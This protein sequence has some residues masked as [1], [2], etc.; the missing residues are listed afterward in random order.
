M[1]A[2]KLW[3]AFDQVSEFDRGRIEG[4]TDRRDRS[5]ILQC[6]TSREGRQIVR[7]AETDRSVTSRIIAQHIAS[8]AH[9]S[10]SSRT[11]RCRLQQSCPSLRRPCLDLPLTQNL[12]RIHRQWSN[13]RRKWV[14]EWN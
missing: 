14:T 8:I 10:V 4:T 12:R 6:T 7:T 9:H 13:K 5:H 11:I 2:R 3:S 1:S